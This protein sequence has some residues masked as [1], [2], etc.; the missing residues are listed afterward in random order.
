MA[1]KKINYRA[2]RCPYCGGSVT[3]R[4][5]DGIYNENKKGVMLYVC[6]NYPECDAYVR[7]HQGTNVPVGGMADGKLRAL[8]KSAHDSFDKLYL[9]KLMTKNEAY[10][11]LA[12]L[13]QCPLS[14]AHIG[15]L[16]EYYC[17]MVIRESR[18]EYEMLLS[19]RE[20]RKVAN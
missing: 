15:N 2:M 13:L 10:Y 12:G 19:R 20:R 14:K 17:E 18:R 4:S 7:V 8:R 16:G 11:W 6:S 9:T 5:A 3:Y 1:K